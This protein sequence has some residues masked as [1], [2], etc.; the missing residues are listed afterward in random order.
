MQRISGARTPRLRPR[1]G[2]TLVELLVVIAIIGILIALLL[3]AVQAARVAAR[4]AQ[5]S[6]NLKQL[7][8]ATH[9][10]ADAHKRFPMGCQN[11]SFPFGAPRQSWLPYVLPYLEEQNVLSKYD[12]D[13]HK[14][15]NG[16][17]SYDVHFQTANS[18]TVD[19]STS[20]VIP[21]LLCPTDIGVTTGQ[22]AWGYFSFGNYLAVFGGLTL[23][24][25]NPATIQPKDRAAF[26]VN[27]GAEFAEFR[28]GA[29]KTMI[30]AEYLRST[31]E[32]AASGV[33]ID[34]RGMLWQADEPGG[35][36]IYTAHSPNS[37]TPDIFYPNSWCVPRPERN[38]P[39][40]VGV[41]SG[42]DHTAGARSLHPGGVVVALG[43][44]SVRFI[45]DSI[46]LDLW[47][48]MATIAGGEVVEI[49]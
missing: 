41:T 34:Q 11:Q 5:C 39:C 10:H 31:G 19:A 18:M 29:S 26:G 14:G 44:G 48:D 8:L 25:A 30:Y 42:A 6:N 23:G 16:I 7:A 36:S 45:D 17:Y 9:G 21:S 3:P 37:S 33:M 47:Q 2:F 24:G 43:D 35:G 32:T 13:L 12:F 4:R 49:P 38:L 1:H 28:D 22:F 46:H 15:A 27:F 40:M 20:V